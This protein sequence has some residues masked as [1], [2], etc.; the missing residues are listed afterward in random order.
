M[1][2]LEDILGQGAIQ[3]PDGV[4]SVGQQLLLLQDQVCFSASG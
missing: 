1:S 2:E 3:T 4:K